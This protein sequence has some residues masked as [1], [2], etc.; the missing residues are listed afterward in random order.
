MRDYIK[1]A[2]FAFDEE[3]KHL[4]LS[5]QKNPFAVEIVCGEVELLKA[6]HMFF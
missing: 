3:S 4:C 6:R 1:K 5:L 2:F